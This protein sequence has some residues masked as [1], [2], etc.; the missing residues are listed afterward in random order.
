MHRMGAPPWSIRVEDSADAPDIALWLRAA[1]RIDAPA[2]GLV[3]GP[4]II[5]PLPESTVASS[6]D[7][8][9]AWSTWWTAIIAGGVIPTPR[10]TTISGEWVGMMEP[11]FSGLAPWPALQSLARAR[12]GEAKAWHDAREREG[13]R[14]ILEHPPPS[15]PGVGPTLE[16][17]GMR[18]G[19]E[20]VVELL[21]LPVIDDEIRPI[22]EDRLMVSEGA[23]RSPG[24]AERLAAYVDRLWTERYGAG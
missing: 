18:L 8:A 12:Y 10:G 9:A 5:D 13:M 24:F 23:Y 19:H 3:P 14:R 2:G 16:R 22:R 20:A 1:E 21:V 6:R 17:W 7:L 15:L 4:L 11:E